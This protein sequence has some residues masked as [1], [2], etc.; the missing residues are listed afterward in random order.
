MMQ[1]KAV[2]FWRKEGPIC[3]EQR[4]PASIANTVS[5]ILALPFRWFWAV[6]DYKQSNSFA[7]L[8]RLS[9]HQFL[10]DYAAEDED[11]NRCWITV[12]GVD[13]NSG[14]LNKEGFYGALQ[15]F[16]G[17]NSPIKIVLMREVDL[18]RVHVFVNQDKNQTIDLF[19][20]MFDINKDKLKKRRY[21][22]LRLMQLESLFENMTRSFVN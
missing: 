20:M 7:E 21:S 3:Y 15:R 13:E 2:L 5:E 19:L 22:Q 6:D 10:L 17:G 14:D 11:G 9:L 1:E 18:D 8:N 4:E 12:L 16:L